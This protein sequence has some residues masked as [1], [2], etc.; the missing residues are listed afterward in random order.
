MTDGTHEDEETPTQQVP[1]ERVVMPVPN[2]TAEGQGE[3][4]ELSA[5]LCGDIS[6]QEHPRC[7]CHGHPQQGYM[8]GMV[9]VGGK[10]CCSKE[11]C[12][13]KVT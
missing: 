1:H 3:A 11:P 7:D 9:T 2:E 13:H 12:G 8:C 10:Y 4:S 5:L 6:E